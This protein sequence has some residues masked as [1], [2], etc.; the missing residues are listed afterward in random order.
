MI[1]CKTNL[2]GSLVS[3]R[4]SNSSSLDRKKNRGKYN[5]F[6]SRYSFSPCTNGIKQL[7]QT[8]HNCS[9]MDYKRTTNKTV[10]SRWVQATRLTFSSVPAS[11]QWQQQS[12]RY[13]PIITKG[14]KTQSKHCFLGS[15]ILCL[16][17]YVAFPLNRRRACSLF[18]TAISIA[19]RAREGQKVRLN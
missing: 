6:F 18:H 11:F 5:L 7:L 8:P 13:G 19:Q 1:K 9:K 17:H 10:P 14:K 16:Y 3:E 12:E 2:F 15:C 4:I